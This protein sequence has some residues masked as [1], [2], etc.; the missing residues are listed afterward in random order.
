[1]NVQIT[2]LQRSRAVVIAMAILIGVSASFGTSSA[3]QLETQT[4][5][6]GP[7]TIK[8][9]P[10]LTE[11]TVSFVIVLDTHS[12]NLDAYDLGQLA[13]A[14]TDDGLEVLPETWEAPKGGHHREGT[15]AFPRVGADGRELIGPDT[16]GLELVIR[17]IGGV[18]ITVIQ[19]TAVA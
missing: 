8:A 9:T 4:V 19:W 18:S 7:V 14:R 6:A 5:Q 3:Q 2:T 15:L 10:Q 1:M 17:D 12:V 13:I 16:R 11:D